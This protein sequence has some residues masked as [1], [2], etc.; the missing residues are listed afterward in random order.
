MVAG[1]RLPFNVVTS[2]EQV[3]PSLKTSVFFIMVSTCEYPLPFFF[4]ST[5]EY[6]RLTLEQQYCVFRDDINAY[7]SN[8]TKIEF[9]KRGKIAPVI[10][11]PVLYNEKLKQEKAGQSQTYPEQQQQQQQRQQVV[12]PPTGITPED[13]SK[14]GKREC[15]SGAAT[16]TQFPV[17]IVT[18]AISTTDVTTPGQTEPPS[19]KRKKDIVDLTVR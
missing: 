14:S 17:Q 16:T 9:P 4:N 8:T 19:K 2:P 13:K 6:V 11:Y 12:Q 3:S 7:L 15:A 10:P 1:M 18:P 5:G